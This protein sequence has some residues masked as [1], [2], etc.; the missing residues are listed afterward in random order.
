MNETSGPHK[1]RLCSA[2]GKLRA[3]NTFRHVSAL[4]RLMFPNS[5]IR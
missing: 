1:P 2:I 5:I 4:G 3:P